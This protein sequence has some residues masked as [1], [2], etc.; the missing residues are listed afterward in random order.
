ML[1]RIVVSGGT[2]RDWLETVWTGA[3]Y[4]ERCETPIF[5]GGTSQEIVFQEVVSNSASQDE[6]L[7]TLAGR[8]V[9]TGKQRGGHIK[10]KVTEPGY[11]MCISSITP[12]IDYSQGNEFDMDFDNMDDIHKPALDGIGYQDSLNG[13]RAWWADYLS[14]APLIAK[15][16]AGKT[17]AWINY[18]T[19]VN[20]VYGNFAA[21]MS[22]EFMVLNRNYSMEV[23]GNNKSIED[24]TTYIDPVKYNYIFADTNLDAMNFWL[25]IKFDITA[26]RLISAK[27]IPYL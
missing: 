18:M 4:F 22:E 20:K 14:E 7:G 5:E 3:N 26:R 1:N 23:S 2:Y 19:N 6:P 8:G 9:T 21:G 17:V 12:R 13:E 24:L 10:I 16:A 11:I 25:Q 27:Q 15:T